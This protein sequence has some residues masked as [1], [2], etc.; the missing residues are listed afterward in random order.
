MMSVAVEPIPLIDPSEY[1]PENKKESDFRDFRIHTVPERVFRTYDLMHTNQTLEYAKNRLESWTKFN[2]AE[3]TILEAI[4][5]LNGLV[6]ES[7]P[8]VDFPNSLHAFQT[9]EAIRQKHP[10]N[11]WF[12][13][14]GL[15]H[16]LGKMMALWGE[17]QWAVVGDTFPVGCL[18]DESIVFGLESFSKNPDMKNDKLNTKLGIYSENCGLANV[19]MSWGHDEYLYRVLK[20]NGCTLPEE[21]LYMIRF[22]SFYPW[23]SCGAYRHLCS[24][25]DIDMMKW[26]NEFNQFDLYTKSPDMPDVDSILPYYSELVEKFCPGKL[27]W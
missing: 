5:A 12:Q 15:I 14:T 8:D 18:P 26:V 3:M 20:A 11:T 21:A 17:P 13:V 19:T 7:D 9:A 25:K 24:N 6:D 23:H 10:T 1:R 16:D 2:H 4:E 27:R 22:H